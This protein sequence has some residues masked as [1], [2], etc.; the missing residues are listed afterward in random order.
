MDLSDKIVVFT[1]ATSGL[2]KETARE[3]AK[4]NATLVIIARN[5]ELA[6]Q[7]KEEFVRETNNNK[8]EFIYGD[9]SSLKSVKTAAEKIR[10]KYPKIDVL[11]NNAGLF[12]DKRVLSEDGYELTFA[13]D[14]LAH[15]FLV[16]LLIE[17][18]K[19]ATPARIINVASDIHLFFGLKIN[20]LQQEKRYRSFKAYAH[21]KS[22]MVLHTYELHNRLVELGVTVNAFHPGK[23]LTKQITENLPKI[24]IKL[25][26]NYIQPEV[27]AKALVHLASSDEFA[28]VSGK[29]FQ[30]FKMGKSSKQSYDVD[31]Q[32]R[33]W[34]ESLELIQAVFKDF[35]SPI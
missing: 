8:T 16:L 10:K 14:Y 4:I 23:V 12:S 17:N 26:R 30:K 27:A 11:I 3:L 29:Y 13:V 24:A 22:A 9:L 35:E 20:D 6:K 18:L 25:S 2:G 5:K 34:D 32:K 1:G 28:N 15:F 21:A 33:L 7:V 19:A 31:L